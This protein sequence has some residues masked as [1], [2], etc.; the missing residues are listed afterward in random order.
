[1]SVSK[2]VGV[3]Y[4]LPPEMYNTADSK[5]PITTGDREALS[6]LIAAYSFSSNI[7]DLMRFVSTLSS[8]IQAYLV[9]CNRYSYYHAVF[10]DIT[11]QMANARILLANPR[12][13]GQAA[14]ILYSLET[15]LKIIAERENLTQTA[16]SMYEG[17]MPIMPAEVVTIDSE[18][19][20]NI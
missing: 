9:K 15:A 7:H 5:K 17:K 4:R 1:M 8:T 10:F 6:A 2:L 11:N 13:Y 19:P 3:G 18:D 12:S 14:V 16:I 20:Y